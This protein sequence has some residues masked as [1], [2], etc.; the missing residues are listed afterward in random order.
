MT[1]STITEN[2]DLLRQQNEFL[3]RENASKNTMVK[4]SVGNQHHA[5]NTKKLNSSESFKTVKSTFI[6]NHY[7]PKSQKV[8][9]S[10]RYDTLYQRDDS[11]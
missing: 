6:K 9:C 4:I 2:T 1:D 7:K 8:V 3:L 10:N 5:N 11:D